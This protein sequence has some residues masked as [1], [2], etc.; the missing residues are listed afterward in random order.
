MRSLPDPNCI[1]FFHSVLD[2]V[3][4]SGAIFKKYPDEFSEQR[5]ISIDPA[6]RGW[7]I[8]RFFLS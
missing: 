3:Q 2:L 4:S 7:K 6:K 1:A 5:A 8:Y